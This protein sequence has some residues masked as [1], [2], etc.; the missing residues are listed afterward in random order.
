MDHKY[1]QD[2]LSAYLDKELT[3]ELSALMD[4]HLKVCSECR[5]QL[6]RLENLQKLVARH[7]QLDGED[8]W[9]HSA[10]RR[11]KSL[12]SGGGNQNVPPAWGG[13]SRLS[14]PQS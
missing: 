6:G 9:E 13:E 11:L 5:D 1:F 14:R 12:I 4:E 8:Y 3:P 2:L 7:S 10:F